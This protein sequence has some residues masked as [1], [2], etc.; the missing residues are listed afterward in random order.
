MFL[1]VSLKQYVISL[2]RCLLL[3]ISEQ[4]T[5]IFSQF[6]EISESSDHVEYA[7]V[8]HNKFSITF[9]ITALLNHT[10]IF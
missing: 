9:L 3:P 5:Q 7:T 1:E 6:S 8:C 4:I 2:L 10:P